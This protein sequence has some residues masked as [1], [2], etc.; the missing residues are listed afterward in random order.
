MILNVKHLRQIHG[1]LLVINKF[2]IMPLLKSMTDLAYEK[3]ALFI[4]V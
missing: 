4:G 3:N 1:N 2:F